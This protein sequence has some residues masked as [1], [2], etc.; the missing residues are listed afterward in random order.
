MSI[1]DLWNSV[2]RK[3]GTAKDACVRYMREQTGT[4]SE[5]EPA[6]GPSVVHLSE[7]T[8]NATPDASSTDDRPQGDSPRQEKPPEPQPRRS[9]DGDDP[10]TLAP[11]GEAKAA[12]EARAEEA[13]LAEGTGGQ[14]RR[15]PPPVPG[16]VV[17][18]E[19]MEELGKLPGALEKLSAVLEQQRQV[20]DRISEAIA[21]AT[22]SGVDEEMLDTLRDL[23][24]ESKRQTDAMHAVLGTVESLEKSQQQST[25]TLSKLN[26]TIENA[27]RANAS[28]TEFMEQVRDHLAGQ[29]DDMREFIESHSAK[30]QKIGTAIVALLGVLILAVVAG[31][32]V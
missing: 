18:P 25:A 29:S 23:S 9:P 4:P 3:L 8:E 24:S 20:P 26:E 19:G 10:P 13:K 21:R 16:Q 17:L 2:G 1:R 22:N 28:L 32:F 15:Q 31:M 5:P 12:A 30:L 7:Q 11:A 6:E 14:T 27:N